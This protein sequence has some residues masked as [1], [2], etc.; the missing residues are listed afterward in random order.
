MP[1]T[2]LFLGMLILNE[3]PR[4][5][6]KIG[7]WDFATTELSKIR[8][9]PTNHD[10]ILFELSEM[11]EQLGRDRA[12]YSGRGKLDIFRE[13]FFVRTNLKRLLLGF[14]LM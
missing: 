7:E 14:F 2:I 8:Q 5:L 10:Y 6:A 1:S 13:L 9:L 11:R 3:S 4:W 12:V